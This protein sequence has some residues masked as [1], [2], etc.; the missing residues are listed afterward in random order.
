MQHLEEA[1]AFAQGKEIPLGIQE[2]LLNI[3]QDENPLAVYQHILGMFFMQVGQEY[4]ATTGRPRRTGWLDLVAL[5]HAVTVNGLT[6]LV[7]TKLDCL[8]D[9]PFVKIGMAYEYGG[10]VHQEFSSHFVDEA[11]PIYQRMEGW[12]SA[13][14]RAAHSFK[15]LPAAAQAYINVITDVTKVPI[16]AL[17]TGAERSQVIEL[18]NP[19][20]EKSG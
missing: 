7:L 8:G 19:F 16:Y 10:E 18:Y 14:V 9:L 1:D 11:K 12:S 3:Y 5:R 17:G 6:G 2:K 20:S 15:E 4:G 13:E